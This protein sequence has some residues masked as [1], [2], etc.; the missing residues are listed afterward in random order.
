LQT[1]GSDFDPENAD[2]IELRVG[3]QVQL[4]KQFDDGWATGTNK[5]TNQTGL[6]PLDCLVGFEDGKP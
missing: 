3:D 5:V 1:V 6:F 4:T 2:E